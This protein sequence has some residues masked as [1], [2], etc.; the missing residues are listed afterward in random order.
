MEGTL[1]EIRGF[2]G[3]FSP[4]NWAYC[5]GQIVSIAQNTSL[6]MNQKL[7][8]YDN[9][10]YSL[11]ISFLKMSLSI[12]FPLDINSIPRIA[13]SINRTYNSI[14]NPISFYFHQTMNCIC[15]YN[16]FTIL[17]INI[18]ILESLHSI[19]LN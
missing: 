6:V 13:I 1:A 16:R 2:A 10:L 18:F 9:H 3:N 12:P 5:Y 15:F 11:F 8:Y 17:N 7:V 4:R 19:S 14:I